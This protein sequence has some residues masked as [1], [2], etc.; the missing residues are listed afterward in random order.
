M[1]VVRCVV[2][3][4][5]S[6]SLWNLRDKRERW[7]EWIIRAWCISMLPL[8]GVLSLNCNIWCQWRLYS[9]RIAVFLSLAAT[10]V[11][12]FWM[13]WGYYKELVNDFFFF[14][15][16]SFWSSNCKNSIQMLHPWLG[17]SVP[18]KIEAP[19]MHL[20]AGLHFYGCFQ[21]LILNV[22]FVQKLAPVSL[23]QRIMIM[24][25]HFSFITYI[26]V[27]SPTC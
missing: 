10:R 8:T 25:M 27:Q 13:Q 20:N 24:Q 15:L 16:L 5:V 4:T 11:V 3:G 6:R 1:H 2:S 21:I 22:G 19:M 23:L 12:L 14:V 7:C 17:Q 26:I 18:L 9:S